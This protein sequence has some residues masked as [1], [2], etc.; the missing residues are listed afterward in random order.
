L[1]VLSVLAVPPTS[2]IGGVLTILA[3]SVAAWMAM[4]SIRFVRQPTHATARRMLHVSLLHLP[5][6]MLLIL[7]S[8]WLA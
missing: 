2:F 5:L 8:H 1:I 7:L 3:L 4:A 6:T